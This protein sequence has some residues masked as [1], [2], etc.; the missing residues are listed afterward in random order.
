MW[1][2]IACEINQ[3]PGCPADLNDVKQVWK[4]GSS[5]FPSYIIVVGQQMQCTYLFYNR[6]P[7]PRAN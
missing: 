1:S 4:L 5:D 2:A 3:L 7:I 6:D